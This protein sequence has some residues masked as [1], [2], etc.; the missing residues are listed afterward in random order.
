MFTPCRRR[1][2]AIF[3]MLS[4]TFG[5]LGSMFR[6]GEYFRHACDAAL[7]LLS[8]P[9]W[10]LMRTPGSPG[11]GSSTLTPCRRMHWA[12]LAARSAGSGDEDDDAF[13]LPEP[14]PPSTVASASAMA[15]D[16]ITMTPIV[17]IRCHR[18]TEPGVCGR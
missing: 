2:W 13:P 18:C 4:R 9:F 12:N 1:H 5:S 15:T 8:S 3:S 11:L 10:P 16:L 17:E 14:Q 7:I 6:I